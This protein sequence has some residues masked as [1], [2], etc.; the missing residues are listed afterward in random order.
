VKP[1]CTRILASGCWLLLGLLGT[2]H[3]VDLQS[4]PEIGAVVDARVP[5]PT[6]GVRG[7]LFEN[8]SVVLLATANRGLSAPDSTFQVSL[9]RWQASTG[10]LRILSTQTDEFETGLSSDGENWWSSGSLLGTS[11]GIYQISPGSGKVLT[12]LPAPG[13]HPGGIAYDGLYLWVVD[14]DARNIL[15]VDTEEGRVSKKV[16]APAFYPTGL[17]YDG[18]HFWSADASTGRLYRLSGT[19]GRRDAVIAKDA[20]YRPGEFVS[21]SWDGKGLWTVAASDSEAAR[22]QILR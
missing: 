7:F 2:A 18:Y 6:D 22:L 3:A 5:L 4:L 15:R 1:W 14:C 19:T 12:T 11:S 10:N 9:M 21:L 16:A 8:D 13:H 17:A 20:F